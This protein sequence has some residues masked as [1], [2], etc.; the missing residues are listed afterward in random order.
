MAELSTLPEMLP[1]RSYTWDELGSL[2]KF[3]PALLS[4]AGGMIA[5]PKMNAVL[6]ITHPGG[7]RSFDYEDRWDGDTLIYTGRGK[8]GDQELK[9]QNL[10]VAENRRRLLVFE[11]EATHQ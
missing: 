1:N 5:R 2:F 10:D 7:A 3:K 4:A 6:L 11:A 8:T 9:G